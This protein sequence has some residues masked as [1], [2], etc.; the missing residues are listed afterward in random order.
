MLLARLLS[1]ETKN[2]AAARPD[3]LRLSIMIAAYS[4]VEQVQSDFYGAGV[5]D[6]NAEIASSIS[7]MR[8]TVL[9]SSVMSIAIG[10]DEAIVAYSPPISRTLYDP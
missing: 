9:A 6:G 10:G 2:Q 3:R 5:G 8:F 7:C 4:P 1:R